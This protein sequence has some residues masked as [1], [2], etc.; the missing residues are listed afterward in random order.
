[1]DELTVSLTF[2]RFARSIFIVAPSHF[3]SLGAAM[4]NSMQPLNWQEGHGHVDQLQQNNLYA[5]SNPPPQ[6]FGR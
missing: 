6:S 4:P 2:T 3:R 5:D 1:M